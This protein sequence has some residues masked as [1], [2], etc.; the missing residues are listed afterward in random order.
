MHLIGRH[1]ADA[2]VV[3]LLIVPVEEA[4]AALLIESCLSALA[5]IW[6]PRATLRVAAGSQAAQ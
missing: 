5:S 1:Q 4:A 3:M 6:R 2:S